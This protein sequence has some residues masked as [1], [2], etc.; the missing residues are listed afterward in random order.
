ML[1]ERIID[2]HIKRMRK[3]FRNVDADFD[4]IQSL[5]GIGYRFAGGE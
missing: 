3:K 5:Y 1:H 2:S 4:Q